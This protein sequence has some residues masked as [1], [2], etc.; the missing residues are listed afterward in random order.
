MSLYRG[1]SS[2]CSSTNVTST[3]RNCGEYSPISSICARRPII[4]QS[5]SMPPKRA[6]HFAALARL[7]PPF[8]REEVLP[9]EPRTPYSPYP[10]YGEGGQRAERKNLRAF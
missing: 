4:G 1:N 8:G 10:I 6:G 2:V 5:W 9:N 7:L 3:I